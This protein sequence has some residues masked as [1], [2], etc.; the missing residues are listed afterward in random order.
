MTTIEHRPLSASSAVTGHWLANAGSDHRFRLPDLADVVRP[1]L[2]ARLFFD[3][4]V[5]RQS[6]GP[7]RVWLR[8][9]A[10]KFALGYR[11]AARRHDRRPLR[12][13]TCAVRRRP[14]V[15]G[16]A[17]ADV[18]GGKRAAA[19]FFRGPSYRLRPFRHVVHGF[20]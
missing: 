9:G 15:C 17:S 20:A 10:A 18:T 1:A 6:L 8:S 11:P 3:A 7:R 12:F 16:R 2:L 5:E 13:G 14:D 4:D 19:R